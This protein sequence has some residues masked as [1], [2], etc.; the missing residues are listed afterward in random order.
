MLILF[1]AVKITYFILKLCFF[2]FEGK[3]EDPYIFLPVTVC[4][5]TPSLPTDK[6]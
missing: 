4:P 5:P 3:T 2:G 6:V 1:F